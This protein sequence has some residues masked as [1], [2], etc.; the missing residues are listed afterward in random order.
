[1]ALP[2]VPKNTMQKHHPEDMTALE[3]Q[4][5]ID[6]HAHTYQ[7]VRDEEGIAVN[8][9]RF[10]SGD[11]C[12]IYLFNIRPAKKAPNTPSMPTI[13]ERAALMKSIAMHEDKLHHGIAVSA[14]ETIL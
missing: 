10:I 7:E 13:C 11:T 3:E 14:Q 9:S 6:Q 12:G 1:M 4:S 8:S 5:H 2:R